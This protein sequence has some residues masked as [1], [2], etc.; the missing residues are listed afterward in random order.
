[1]GYYTNLAAAFLDEDS[2]YSYTSP[3]RELFWRMDDLESRLD[4]LR[5]KNACYESHITVP[6]DIRYALP[7][8]LGTISE[9]KRAIEYARNDLSDKYGINLEAFI[10]QM[11]TEYEKNNSEEEYEQI[12]FIGAHMQ[13]INHSD[14]HVA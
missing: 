3:E 8:H 7:E 14:R 4:E 13:I 12:S 10:D 5:S 9:V 1:M 6:D 11:D 2:D